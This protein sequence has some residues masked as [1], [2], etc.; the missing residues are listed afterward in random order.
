MRKTKIVCTIGPSSDEPEQIAALLKAGMNVARINLS[1]GSQ[2]EQL[3]KA[4]LIKEISSTLKIPCAVMADLRGPEIRTIQKAKSLELARGDS[5]EINLDH[6]PPGDQSISTSHPELLINSVLGDRLIFGDGS[7]AVE[8][9]EAQSNKLVTQVIDG[10]SL[11]PKQRITLPGKTIELPALV[12]EDYSDVEA[13][14]KEGVDF[15]AQS[16]VRNASDI[17]ILRKEIASHNSK[18]FIIAKIEKASA[19]DNIDEI[20]EAADGIMVARGDLGIELPPEDVPIVQKELIRAAMLKGKP[21]ITATQMLESM[22]D[23]IRPTR[24]E[25]SDVA[26]AIFDGTDAIM[27]SGETATGNF[28]VEAVKMMDKIAI[29]TENT[30]DYSFLLR[31]KRSWLR[32]DPTSAISYSSCELAE[33]LGAKAIITSTQSGNTARQV[34]RYRPVTPIIAITSREDTF[35]KLLLSWGV[36][37]ALVEPGTNTDELFDTAHSKA[38]ELKA[39]EPGEILIITAGVLVNM[40][41]TTN[42]IKVQVA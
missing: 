30:I 40:P 37:P 34:S 1:H 22:I 17:A 36:T 39:A 8:V 20:L 25:A 2:E 26:N 41:G 11:V 29:K 31:Q 27:L 18:A 19:I 28:P 12:E 42:L 38:L 5:L 32:D 23:N 3:G 4:R 13:F 6:E 9:V 14:S 16:F 7:I 15:F 35:G 24:A 33:N 10:G 21:V